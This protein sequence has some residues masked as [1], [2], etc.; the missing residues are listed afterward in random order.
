MYRVGATT[1]VLEGSGS[2]QLVSRCRSQRFLL[3]DKRP[4]SPCVR[5]LGRVGSSALYGY[6]SLQP[7]G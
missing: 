1:Y 3:M 2:W 7:L 4:P 5:P 6:P